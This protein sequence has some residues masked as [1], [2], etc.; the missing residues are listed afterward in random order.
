MDINEVKEIIKMIDTSSIGELKI[1]TSDFKM[2]LKRPS[3]SSTNQ[4]NKQNNEKNKNS[5][6][7][8]KE[9]NKDED[10]EDSKKTEDSAKNKNEEKK[11]SNEE[12]RNPNDNRRESIDERRNYGIDMPD[13]HEQIYDRYGQRDAMNDIHIIKSPI[14]GTYYASPTPYE[15]PL[16]KVGSHIRKGDVLCII[17]AMKLMNEIKSDVDG[18]VAEVHVKNEKLVEYGQPLFTIRV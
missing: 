11:G 5:E 16:I 14:V 7:A 2:E 18:E 1:E 17:E 9:D 10:E 13:R 8:S 15:P 12:K 3:A 4:G 6:D